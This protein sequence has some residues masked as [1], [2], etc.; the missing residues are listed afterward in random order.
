MANNKAWCAM[1]VCACFGGPWRKTALHQRCMMCVPPGY[2]SSSPG[3]SEYEWQRSSVATSSFF[4]CTRSLHQHD[5]RVLPLLD[6]CVECFHMLHLTLHA[7]IYVLS[8]VDSRCG[9]YQGI[10]IF[11]RGD[12]GGTYVTQAEAQGPWTFGL[13]C[14]EPQ[15]SLSSPLTPISLC[16]F[17]SAHRHILKKSPNN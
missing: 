2:S 8:Q 3:R 1:G 15:V 11:N 17:P 12:Q 14:S 4:P 13:L 9:G 16:W 10:R 5:S 7:V 6:T